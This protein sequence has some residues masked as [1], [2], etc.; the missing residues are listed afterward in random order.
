MAGYP[1]SIGGGAENE[2]GS[3]VVTVIPDCSLTLD[4]CQ[5]TRESAGNDYT[6]SSDPVHGTALELLHSGASRVD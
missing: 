1:R 5:T 6:T 2:W 3:S 4:W